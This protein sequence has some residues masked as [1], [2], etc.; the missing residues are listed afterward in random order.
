ME[1]LQFL[2]QLDGNILLWIQQYI[3]QPFLTEFFTHFTYLGNH[4]IIQILIALLFLI[5]KKTRKAGII[6]IMGLLGTLLFT[7]LILK[8]MVAR[9]R[10]Y[11]VIPGLELLIEKQ[12][13]FSFP[14]GHS[15]ASF[16]IAEI[17]Y[18]CF[19]GWSGIVALVLAALMAFSRLYV[20]VHYPSDV[21]AGALLGLLIGYGA[22]K[23]YEYWEREREKTCRKS[24]SK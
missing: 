19:H 12:K 1:I 5:P 2:Q 21:L 11:E 3:R 13:D 24:C 14:S 17:I 8:N 16:I 22:G 18:H 9:I 20:G 23:L 7:N 4:G 10:P 6:C 15:A